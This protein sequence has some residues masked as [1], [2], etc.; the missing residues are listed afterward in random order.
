ME[1]LVAAAAAWGL[2][3]VRPLDGGVVA[4]T[5]A[6]TRNGRPV[7]LKLN[8]RGHPE[9]AQLAAE[10]DALAFWRPTGAAAK[11]LDQRDEGFTLLM[12]RLDPGHAVDDAGLTPEQRLT[13]LGRLAA[14]LHRAGPPPHTFIHLRKFVP[15]WPLPPETDEVLLHLDL[16]GGNAL[17]AGPVWKVIDPKGIRGDRHADVWALIDAAML[18]SLPEAPAEAHAT[19]ARWTERYA[20][21]AELDLDRT[22]GWTHMRARAEILESGGWPGLDRMADALG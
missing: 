12:E 13:E 7:V 9:D 1:R 10:G 15:A 18:E 8:P 11:L 22:R 14:T 21:A 16:H 3:G 17:R 2:S 20:E 6:A 19:A 4:L 5:C